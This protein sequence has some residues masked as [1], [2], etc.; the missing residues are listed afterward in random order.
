[1]G[2]YEGYAKYAGGEVYS[3]Q[4]SEERHGE[5]PQGPDR[6]ETGVPEGGPIFDGYYCE[7]GCGHESS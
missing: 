1:M 7:C 3:T 5:C 6:E 2:D 4:C